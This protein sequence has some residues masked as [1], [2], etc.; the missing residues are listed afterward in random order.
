MYIL[1][2]AN[3]TEDIKRKLNSNCDEIINHLLKIWLFP[4]A[5]EQAHWKQEVYSFLHSVNK[6]KLT[7]GYPSKKFI[8]NATWGI[9]GDTMTD[10][11]N[12]LRYREKYYPYTCIEVSDETVETAVKSYF[13]WI[14]QILSE[15]GEASRSEVYDEIEELRNEL[16]Q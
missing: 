6:Q 16:I 11:I 12:V 4:D 10:K 15:W 2:F 8:F 1:G 3:K 14:S 5:C 13:I 9:T 7:K